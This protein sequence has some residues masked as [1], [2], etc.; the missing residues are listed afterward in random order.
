MWP[1]H[2]LI[3]FNSYICL[4]T[5]FHPC[6]LTFIFVFCSFFI[7]LLYSCFYDIK[8]T[9]YLEGYNVNITKSYRKQKHCKHKRLFVTEETVP[10]INFPVL[11]EVDNNNIIEGAARS[12]RSSATDGLSI[13]HGHSRTIATILSSTTIYLMLQQVFRWWWCFLPSWKI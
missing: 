5:N 10:D 2:V 12:S 3:I 13:T 8:N 7:V 4:W 9:E 1:I 11:H 6:N